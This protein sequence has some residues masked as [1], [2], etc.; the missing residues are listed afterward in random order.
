M[1][2]YLAQS[3]RQ[4]IEVETSV[5]TS[6]DPSSDGFTISEDGQPIATALDARAVLDVVYQRVH[7]RL[8]DHA[9]L[10]GWVRAHAALVETGGRRVALCGPAGVGKTTLAVRLL[11]DGVAV[12]GD[13]S[14]L[15]RDGESL[16]VPRPFHLKPG[17]EGHVP[18]IAPLL[19]SLPEVS[20][21]TPVRAFDPTRAGFAWEI[22]PGRIDDVVLLER[23]EDTSLEPVTATSAMQ[24][25]VEQVFLLHEPKGSVVREVA[26]VL[27]T[28]R[29]FR[30]RV[31]DPARCAAAV[32]ELA[33]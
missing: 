4:H 11:F 24:G 22:A 18:E 2:G 7:Q 9:S 10:S 19:S 6:V 26:A 20:D 21:G 32:R 23:A 33:V 3:A 27:R 29:C 25:I 14:V 30:L 17:I 1:L 31:S 5:V 15:L 12:H 28:A 8:F 16:A 13:E